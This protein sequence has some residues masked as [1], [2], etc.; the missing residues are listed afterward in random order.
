[1][2]R[3]GTFRVATHVAGWLL[4][5]ALPLLFLN[6]G[7]E[8]NSV[9]LLSLPFYWLFCITYI[10]L[11]YFNAHLLIPLLFFKKKYLSYSTIVILMLAGI[12]FLQPY[13]RLMCS[14]FTFR[15]LSI[16]QPRPPMRDE[17]RGQ[18]MPPPHRDP[19]T[20][21]GSMYRPGP[22]AQ[23]PGPPPQHQNGRQH[24]DIIS[25]FLFIM[26]IALSSAIKIMQQWQL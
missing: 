17:L 1:M 25:F 7:G 21:P 19:G 26:I 4:F 5:M 14:F 6:G 8:D 23:P 11:F 10:I 13:D 2:F 24:F 20:P 9:L 15:H 3:V 22:G 16:I 18:S 12:Y